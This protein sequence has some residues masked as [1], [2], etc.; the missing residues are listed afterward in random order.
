MMAEFRFYV[1]EVIM[2]L[3]VSAYPAV[4]FYVMVI[5]C[6]VYYIVNVISGDRRGSAAVR[7]GA[8]ADHTLDDDCQQ[9]PTHQKRAH[10]SSHCLALL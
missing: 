4:I 2:F 6:V 7:C 10:L 8:S 3:R 1:G 5:G 9:P